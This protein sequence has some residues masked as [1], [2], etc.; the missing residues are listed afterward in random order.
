MERTCRAEPRRSTRRY[1]DDLPDRDSG[2]ETSRMTRERGRSTQRNRP[3]GFE[4]LQRNPVKARTKSEACAAGVAVWLLEVYAE[5]TEYGEKSDL[6]GD[7]RE[8][9]TDGDGV[10]AGEGEGSVEIGA[11]RRSFVYSERRGM[12]GKSRLGSRWG[13]GEALC[14]ADGS[15]E[16]AIKGIAWLAEYTS[17]TGFDSYWGTEYVAGI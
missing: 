16:R 7:T 3:L 9:V 14:S 13:D 2:T 5:Y 12:G 6:D 10:N 17:W 8:G 4:R 15:D 11:A 1:L